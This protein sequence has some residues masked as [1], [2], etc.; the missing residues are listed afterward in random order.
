MYNQN[1]WPAGCVPSRLHLGQVL[2]D[3]PEHVVVEVPR[4]VEVV[5][6]GRVQP[7]T[8]G[9]RSS[10]LMDRP[11]PTAQETKR[12]RGQWMRARMDVVYKTIEAG[13]MYSVRLCALEVLL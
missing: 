5:Q 9:H 12:G 13:R 7:R 1:N 11:I 10:R 8:L 3:L 6:P 2:V 4:L